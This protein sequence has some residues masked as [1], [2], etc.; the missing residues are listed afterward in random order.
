MAASRKADRALAIT[1][2]KLYAESLFTPGESVM[3]GGVLFS[4]PSLISQGLLR[5][6]EVF[7][8]LP[9][10]FYGLHHIVLILCFMALC[11]IKN[12]E[13]LKKVP[14]GEFGKIIGLDRIPQVEYFREKI[15]QITD[16]SRCDELHSVLFED[17]VQSMNQSEPFFYIDGHVRVYSGEL[18]HLPKHFVSG[19]VTT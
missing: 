6:F 15:K 1:G 2:E 19:P 3:H 10:G 5:I 4:L 7:K 13:Q 8:P 12:P 17:W 18:A 14:A 9:A 11:R 16:Q